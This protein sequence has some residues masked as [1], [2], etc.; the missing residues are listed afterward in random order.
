SGVKVIFHPD[1]EKNSRQVQDQRVFNVV[2]RKFKFLRDV[3]LNYPSLNAKRLN[4]VFHEGVAVW[5]F[6]I[7]KKWRCLFTCNQEENEIIVLK[8]CNHL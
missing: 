4:N 1:Y 3:G 8:I 6:Y 7:S 2:E 5:E